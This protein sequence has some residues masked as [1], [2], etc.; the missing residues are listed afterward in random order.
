MTNMFVQ[1]LEK[2]GV[3]GVE[4]RLERPKVASHGIW[5]AR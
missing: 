2:I 3:T 5:P 1:A 4:P